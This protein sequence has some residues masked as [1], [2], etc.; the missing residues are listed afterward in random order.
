MLTRFLLRLLRILR[1][2][3]TLH[4]HHQATQ[5]MLGKLLCNQQRI[6]PIRSIQDAEFQVFSQWGDD[7]II[8]YLIHSVPIQSRTFVE[9]GVED[10][11][12]SNTRF[13]LMNNNW[14]GL[15]MDGSPNNIAKIRR[16][17]LYWRYD[18]T[19]AQAFV[20]A[21]NINALISDNGFA[22]EIG[23]LHIDVDGMD[24]WIWKAITCVQPTIVIVEY[25]S[26]LG[27]DRSITVPYRPDFDRTKAHFT[28][29]FFGSSLLAL[30]DLAE[31]KGYLFVGSNSNGNNAYFVR[32]DRIG[33]VPPIAPED[34]Y[35]ASASRESR[36]R[37]GHLSFIS[38][39]YR[40]S[41]VMGLP[42]YNTRSKKIE[43]L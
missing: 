26:V 12:E 38:R 5:M 13:L 7:G 1:N 39:Q 6:A 14:Q 34:G 30:C 41:A 20:T 11:R 21:E 27:V 23:V 28:N 32:K 24:Y 19:A 25:N 8:Q 4:K 31:E 9:F 33:T 22:D 10:Y 16:D 36:T 43:S 35:V 2:E 3:K 15:I 40:L 17:D 42:V 37:D 18:V 29:L